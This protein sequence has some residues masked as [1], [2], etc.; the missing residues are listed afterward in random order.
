MLTITIHYNSKLRQKDYQK[1]SNNLF[2]IINKVLFLFHE[3]PYGFLKNNNKKQSDGF[4]VTFFDEM[5][6]M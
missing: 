6:T 5:T 1:S 4:F 2:L 3:F